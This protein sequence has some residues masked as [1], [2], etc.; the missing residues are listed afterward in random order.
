MS[1]YLLSLI[2]VGLTS[3][4]AAQEE[5]TV[6]KAGQ[7]GSLLPG[8]FDCYNVTG[9]F[10]GRQ[11]CLVTDFGLRPVV[12]IFARDMPEEKEGA[13]PKLLSALDEALDK[14]QEQELR[15]CVVYLSPHARSSATESKI[16]DPAKLVEEARERDAM[17]KRLE[18]KAD[19]LKNVIVAAYP[20]KGP[21]GYDIEPRDTITVIFYDRLKV[22]ARHG[23]AEGQFRAQDADRIM[24]K[25]QEVI[26][27][28]K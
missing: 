3:A 21:P 2:L 5:K 23:Y 4:L 19:K 10:K 16:E 25:V 20:A 15:G 13:L 28:A 14:Y 9:K 6:P 1:R 12:L 18:A 7:A 27:K 8:S 17:L 24:Q 22:V 11:H 26:K